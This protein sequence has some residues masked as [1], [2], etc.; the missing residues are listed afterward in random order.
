MGPSSAPRRA[1]WSPANS[2]S[3]DLFKA[4]A[5]AFEL[6]HPRKVILSDSGNFPTDLYV[7]ER[8]CRL[9]GRGHELTVVDPEAVEGALDE[10][11][12]VLM[13]TEVDYRTGRR[14]DMRSIADRAKAFGAVTIWDLAHSAR[15][16]STS[17]I[18]A[19]I[20]PS[21]AAINI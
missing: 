12:A 7:A 10:R 19:S 14:H 3:I 16:R 18:A 8:I 21:A 13:L 1:R 20:S 2:T 5:A 4:L 17:P 9:I 6:A 11:V 15:S